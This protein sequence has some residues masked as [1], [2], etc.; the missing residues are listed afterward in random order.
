M[1]RPALAL[2]QPDIAGNTGSLIRLSACFGTKLHIIEPCGF[3]A[4]DKA[5]KRAGMDYAEIANVLRHIDFEG[6]ENW[7]RDHARRLILLSTRATTDYTQFA[8]GAGDVLMLGR[9]SAG[10]PEHVHQTADAQVRIS[11]QPP[12]RSLNQAIAGAIVL[13]EALRQTAW[14]AEPT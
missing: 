10:A 5:L 1:M 7:R 13:S 14:S 9:E 12:A 11:M 6:F 3:R 8:F 2:Y 4:D